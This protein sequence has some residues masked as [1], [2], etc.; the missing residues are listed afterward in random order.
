MEIIHQEGF[1]RNRIFGVSQGIQI[2][3]EFLK[4]EF[5]VNDNMFELDA[6]VKSFIHVTTRIYENGE[7]CPDEERFYMLKIISN[8]FLFFPI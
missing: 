6:F 8:L 7:A 4:Y 2:L 3:N 1:K 5:F